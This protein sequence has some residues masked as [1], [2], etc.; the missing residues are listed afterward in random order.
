MENE[1]VLNEKNPMSVDE[2][3]F[4]ETELVTGKKKEKVVTETKK[5]NGKTMVKTLKFKNVAII[6]KDE[7]GKICRERIDIE[8]PLVEKDWYQAAVRKMLSCWFDEQNILP[9]QIIQVQLPSS[10]GIEGEMEA[11]FLEKPIGE[12]DKKDCVNAAIYHRCRTVVSAL[13]ADAEEMQRSLFLHLHNLDRLDSEQY[14]DG[15]SQ[16]V[17]V[18]FDPEYKVAMIK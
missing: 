13:S 14:L 5:K 11:A 16:W 3:S 7:I 4:D 18:P 10:G 9:T 1:V 15:V 8:V 6:Y 17:E 12:F 2:S